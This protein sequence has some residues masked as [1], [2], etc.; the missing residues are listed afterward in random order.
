MNE[1]STLITHERLLIQ[2][3]S[4][5]YYTDGSGID[6]HVDAATV[7]LFIGVR[8]RKYV[9]SLEEY[10]VYSSE[11]YE[12]LLTLKLI[13]DERT[14]HSKLSITIFIDNQSAIKTLT[15]SKCRS[16]QFIV[17]AIMN[18]ARDLDA[19]IFIH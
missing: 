14:N 10:S 11:L 8:R 17:R 1:L 13:T 19:S 7:S 15:S 9:E 12:I 4:L 6:E 5:F 3:L 18:K 2:E 16:G